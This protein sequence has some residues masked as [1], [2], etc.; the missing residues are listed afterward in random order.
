MNMYVLCI[1]D[2][3]NNTTVVYSTKAPHKMYEYLCAQYLSGV[4]DG[5]V[6][7]YRHGYEV[8]SYVKAAADWIAM[9]EAWIDRGVW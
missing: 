5:F 2:D 9:Y 6:E 1:I 3:S 7:F 4:V 8:A